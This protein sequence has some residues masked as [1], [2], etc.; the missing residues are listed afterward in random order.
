MR[1]KSKIIL[2]TELVQIHDNGSEYQIFINMS[3]G[4][5]IEHEPMPRDLRGL[6]AALQ[7]ATEVCAGKF[8]P[9][10]VVRT[11]KGQD[12]TPLLVS[13]NEGKK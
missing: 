5:Q 2:N 1:P 10:Q 12:T 11:D 4:G 3:R 9:R 7:L 13:K 6:V 8:F